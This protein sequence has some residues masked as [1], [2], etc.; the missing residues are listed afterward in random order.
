[1]GIDKCIGFFQACTAPYKGFTGEQWNLSCL[2]LSLTVYDGKQCV[3]GYKHTFNG[4][5]DISVTSMRQKIG[6][7]TFCAIVA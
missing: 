3:Y 5:P 7:A 6:Y 4:A 2:W 1:M